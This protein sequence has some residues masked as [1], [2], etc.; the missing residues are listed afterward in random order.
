MASPTG[1]AV[2]A[3]G[4]S[5]RF[6]CSGSTL[7]ADDG[8]RPCRRRV[9]V[10]AVCGHRDTLTPSLRGLPPPIGVVSRDHV[11]R[12]LASIVHGGLDRRAPKVCY[13]RPNAWC[14][15]PDS[16]HGR[17][18]RACIQGTR[19]PALKFPSAL[20]VLAIVLVATWVASFV[21]PSGVYELD[22]TGAPVP[23]SYRELPSCGEAAEGELC[24]DKSL[25]AQFG[26]LW[27]AP[28]NGLYGIENRRPEQ[29]VRTRRACSTGPRR[30][31]CSCWPWAPSS[32]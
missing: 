30:S 24:S 21:I 16:N 15:R 3:T 23:G 19:H 31:S 5:G 28:P 9:A 13:V 6:G 26:R 29:S 22:E 12:R 2:R 14:R 32:R 4:G 11:M 27:R 10:E 20:T 18:S 17:G 1:F 7:L 25:A 8:R